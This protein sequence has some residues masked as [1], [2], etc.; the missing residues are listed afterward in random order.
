MN[1][2]IVEPHSD[3]AFLS[4]HAHIL[5]WVGEGSSVH[6]VTLEDNPRRSIEAAAYAKK[7]GATWSRQTSAGQLILPLGIKHPDHVST[8]SSTGSA[9]RLVLPRYAVRNRATG[10]RTCKRAASRD[11]GYILLEAAR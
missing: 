8:A 11:A 6:I 4:L 9:E 3:D 2:V 10:R 5:K 7:A 1:F